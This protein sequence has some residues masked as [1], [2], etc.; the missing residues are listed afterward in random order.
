MNT[1]RFLVLSTDFSNHI[2]DFF[3]AG[4]FGIHSS[5]ISCNAEVKADMSSAVL[6]VSEESRS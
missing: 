2:S 5:E 4:D 3:F 1:S 6:N